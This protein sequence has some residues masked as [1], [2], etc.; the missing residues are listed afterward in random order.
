MSVLLAACS[1]L[2]YK[3]PPTY[4]HSYLNLDDW[5]F[6]AVKGY[7]PIHFHLPTCAIGLIVGYILATKR[8][9]IP[10][11]INAIGWFLSFMTFFTMMTLT[12]KWNQGIHALPDVF[13]STLY[14]STHRLAWGLC[15]AF[16]TLSCTWGQGGIIN[17]ILSWEGFVSFSRLTYMVYL[18]NYGLM[19]IYYGFVRQPMIFGH[20][21]MIFLFFNNMFLSF[22]TALVLVLIFESPFTELNKVFLD[23]KLRKKIMPVNTVN[24]TVI[25]KNVV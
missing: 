21:A 13:V 2:Y 14:G 6:Y 8:G 17:S 22:L 16:I 7:T 15:L 1:H 19:Y 5:F 9:H 10:E 4:L 18:I 24:G 12:Y 25:L 11:H 3:I 23:G 20:R